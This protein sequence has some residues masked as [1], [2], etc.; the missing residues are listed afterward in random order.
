MHLRSDHRRD[1]SGALRHHSIQF[2]ILGSIITVQNISSRDWHGCWI[3]SQVLGIPS[4]GRGQGTFSQ[5]GQ[6]PYPKHRYRQVF[7]VIITLL[8]HAIGEWES[9]HPLFGVT[10]SFCKC[11]TPSVCPVSVCTTRV[12]KLNT[13]TS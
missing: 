4:L 5:P 12:N 11:S 9:R 10:E 8:K 1:L 3:P 2:T 13:Q 7:I 6:Y